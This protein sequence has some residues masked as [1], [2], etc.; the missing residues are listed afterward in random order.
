MKNQCL[1][2]LDVKFKFSIHRSSRGTQQQR[3]PGL[4]ELGSSRNFICIEANLCPSAHVPALW[5][6]LHPYTILHEQKLWPGD[7]FSKGGIYATCC[8]P[9]H[10]HFVHP[11]FPLCLLQEILFATDFTHVILNENNTTVE[12][13][14]MWPRTN[15]E[16]S[17]LL[18]THQ[19]C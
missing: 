2:V 13:V 8:W 5:W 15:T 19:L 16:Q 18:Q 11:K 6:T 10:H 12:I 17:G 7:I 9:C 4:P 1:L 14:W 3:L